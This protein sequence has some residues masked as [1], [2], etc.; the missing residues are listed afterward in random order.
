MINSIQEK[1]NK[2]THLISEQIV[3]KINFCVI[4][5][6]QPKNSN[7]NVKFKIPF[8]GKF[9]P[10]SKTPRS[11]FMNYSCCKQTF[12]KNI[13]IETEIFLHRRIPQIRQDYSS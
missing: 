10:F 13:E 12:I 3:F 4:G 2:R 8:F 7:F 11:F 6:C 1:D 9:S 5:P